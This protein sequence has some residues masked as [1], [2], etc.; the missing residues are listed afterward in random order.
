MKLYLMGLFTVPALL[1]IWAIVL[2]LWIL[3]PWGKHQ[4]RKIS[5]PWY[6]W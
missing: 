1:I 5:D 3:T 6:R 4:D 2:N